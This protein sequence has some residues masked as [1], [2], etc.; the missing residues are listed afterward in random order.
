MF[1][2]LFIY[3][4]IQNVTW[5]VHLENVTQAHEFA[6]FV[7]IRRTKLISWPHFSGKKNQTG[8]KANSVSD[9]MPFSHTWLWNYHP[10]RQS[11]SIS[12]CPQTPQ[13]NN[14]CTNSTSPDCT[15]SPDANSKS[16]H[17][18]LFVILTSMLATELLLPPVAHSSSCF[19][20]ERGCLFCRN[21]CLLCS[22]L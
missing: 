8:I 21:R 11:A 1:V 17:I 10:I 2:G 4:F 16:H 15:Q 3:L 19:G 18:C 14:W 22:T 12:K 5:H 6:L 7:N 9:T 13:Y 20:F